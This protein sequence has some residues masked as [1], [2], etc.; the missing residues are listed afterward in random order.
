MKR[1]ILNL[2]MMSL[3]LLFSLL[4]IG[5]SSLQDLKESIDE[6]NIEYI[7]FKSEDGKQSISALSSW[8]N[9]ELSDIA[10]I[11]IAN[12]NQ[13]KYV[14]LVHDEKINF[15]D[16]FQLIDYTNIIKENMMS[17]IVNGTINTDIQELSVNGNNAQYFE[18]AGEVDKIKITYLIMNV[19]TSD[20]FYQVVGWT[21]TSL[22]EENKSEILEILNSFKV[23]E[24]SI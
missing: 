5:C 13:E 7:E 8:K 15:S 12:M 11:E 14:M 21:L 18:L 24:D 16:D 20:A 23:V 10:S 9:Q 19:E 3:I 2:T 17:I 1:K 4:T 22:F 6:S